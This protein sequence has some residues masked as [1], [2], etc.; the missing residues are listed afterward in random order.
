MLIFRIYLDDT[1]KEGG[2]NGSSPMTSYTA[3][4]ISPMPAG[5]QLYQAS[6]VTTPVSIS[7]K[8][9]HPSTL[10]KDIPW[11]DTSLYLGFD[12]DKTLSDTVNAYSSLELIDKDKKSSAAALL[13]DW[14]KDKPSVPPILAS[15]TSKYGKPISL[16]SIPGVYTEITIDGFDKTSSITTS[17]TSDLACLGK[18]T[19]TSIFIPMKDDQK[20]SLLF[21]E[22]TVIAIPNKDKTTFIAPPSKA[23]SQILSGASPPARDEIPLSTSTP[24]RHDKTSSLAP[25]SF[26]FQSIPSKDKDRSM[27]TKSQSKPQS[28]V[29]AHS[30]SIVGKQQSWRS[31]TELSPLSVP[32]KAT[33]CLT[34]KGQT[35]ISSQIHST[36]S[37]EEYRIYS[38]S[39]DEGKTFLPYRVILS[40]FRTENG[41]VTSSTTAKAQVTLPLL[42]KFPKLASPTDKDQP[43]SSPTDRSISIATATKDQ[44]IAPPLSYG[45][46]Q[47][48]SHVALYELISYLFNTDSGKI[49]TFPVSVYSMSTP[50]IISNFI[51]NKDY[52]TST[53]SYFASEKDKAIFTATASVPA[54]DQIISA[55]SI[56]SSEKDETSFMMSSSILVKEKVTKNFQAPR[57]DTSEKIVGTA[58]FDSSLSTKEKHEHFYAASSKDKE[59]PSVPC[60]TTT[61]YAPK[62]MPTSIGD[63]MP[64]LT[65]VTYLTSLSLLLPTSE[66]V[67]QPPSKSQGF[68]SKAPF[69]NLTSTVIPVWTPAMLGNAYG[70]GFIIIPSTY[71]TAFPGSPRST[72]GVPPG[73]GFVFSEKPHPSNQV[74]LKVDCNVQESVVLTRETT[75]GLSS[76]S[77]IKGTSYPNTFEIQ[78]FS[79]ATLSTTTVPKDETDKLPTISY[80]PPTT[81]TIGKGTNGSIRFGPSLTYVMEFEGCAFKRGLTFTISLIGISALFNIL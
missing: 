49:T 62:P 26:S 16:A 28:T 42:Y 12:K 39:R 48:N 22:S 29:Y 27:P 78:T 10:L 38:F 74:P 68:M 76:P 75:D 3:L 35:T 15:V 6:S 60:K 69:L 40:T 13:Y 81:A 80:M 45:D 70:G 24:Y 20:S 65:I 23:N 59:I 47:T 79:K 53:I 51:P 9:Q 66:E 44:N 72:P 33:T 41:P 18:N 19:I 5:D 30:S 67:V 11:S 57:E 63:F 34:V 46:Q 17:C 31:P 50:S 73:Y 58:I 21:A 7:I 25:S 77:S 32:A 8:D 71:V 43:T 55:A 54:Q 14:Y 1:D 56:M 61:L 36:S 52:T 4:D 2:L 37:P 64:I